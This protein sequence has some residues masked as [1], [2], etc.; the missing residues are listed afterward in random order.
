ME[1]EIR[2]LRHKNETVN[3]VSR[4]VEGEERPNVFFFENK[5]GNGRR[6]WRL[7]SETKRGWTFSNYTI[8][9][10]RIEIFLS[11]SVWEMDRETVI[12]L[13]T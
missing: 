1:A 9:A 4:M 3:G 6:A 13:N 2:T 5:K 8:F 11:R 7:E 10:K 12:N